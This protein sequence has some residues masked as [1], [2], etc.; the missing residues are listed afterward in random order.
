MKNKLTLNSIDEVKLISLQNFLDDN[1][2][3]SVLDNIDLIPF[4]V[5]RFFTV[6]AEKEAIR[7]Q[8][9]HKQC[10][11]L[12][13]CVSGSIEVLC[14]DGVNKSRFILDNSGV[15][16]L[17]PTG[18]WAQEKYLN[19][20]TVLIALCDLP[21]DANDYIYDVQQLKKLKQENNDK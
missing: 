2:M 18:V 1:G 5:L 12:L 3:L 7:G 20:N 13:I 14:D 15:G 10:S 4:K 9:A 21:Y 6:S 16:L 19:D 8:H 11:Q 17:I